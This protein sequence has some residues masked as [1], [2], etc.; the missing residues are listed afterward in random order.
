MALKERL[1]L[2]RGDSVII[3]AWP[4]G[5]DFAGE[6]VFQARAMGLHPLLF[7]EHEGTFW[8][9]VEGLDAAKA[10]K[11]GGPEWAALSKAQ[12]YVFFPGPADAPRGWKFGWG[13]TMAAFPDNGEWYSRAKRH[14][15]RAVRV[16]LGYTSPQRAE[17]YGL[18]LTAWREM[19]IRAAVVPPAVIRTTGTALSRQLLKAKEVHVTAPNGTDLKFRLAGRSPQVDDGSVSPKDIENGDNITSAPGGQIWVAPD[20]SEGTV[21]FDRPTASVGG[22]VKGIQYEFR[23]GKL[24]ARSFAENQGAFERPFVS[25]KGDKDRLGMLSFGLNPE[26]RPGFPQDPITAGVMTLS[27]GDNSELDGKNKTD[28]SFSASLANATLTLDGRPVLEAGRLLV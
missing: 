14:K 16:L 8:R 28:F 12:G 6:F 20:E 1:H 13:R 22:W 4:E 21:I 17:G 7:M 23:G 26:M 9:T 24:I 3:E 19:L 5:L 2:K 25:N 18:D 15:I 10:M 27:L 11:V